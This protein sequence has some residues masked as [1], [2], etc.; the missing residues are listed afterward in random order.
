[1]IDLPEETFW[2]NTSLAGTYGERNNP[3]EHRSWNW[4]QRG[5]LSQRNIVHLQILLG[6]YQ[7]SLNT[8]F[9]FLSMKSHV[10]LRIRIPVI[11]MTFWYVF[12]TDLLFSNFLNFILHLGLIITPYV[13]YVHMTYIYSFSHVSLFT[14]SHGQEKSLSYYDLLTSEFYFYGRI[15][16]LISLLHFFHH[17]T[18]ILTVQIFIIWADLEKSV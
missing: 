18:P 2:R 9:Q 12:G 8:S 16:T 4:K 7:E 13:F 17:P 14:Q 1:M 10:V 3:R 5:V 11:V 15:P 6:L